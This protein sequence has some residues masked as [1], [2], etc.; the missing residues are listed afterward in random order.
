MGWMAC[1]P[2]LV[3]YIPSSANS[4]GIATRAVA[5]AEL[6]CGSWHWVPLNRAKKKQPV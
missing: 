1:A 3:H 4:W 5:F 2:L 6:V